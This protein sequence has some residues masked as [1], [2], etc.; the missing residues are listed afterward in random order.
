MKLR[1]GALLVAGL[2]ALVV[3]GE[4]VAQDAANETG[5][6]VYEK[7]CS[8]CHGEDGNGKGIAAPFLK[9]APRDFTS[10]KYKVRTTP[11]G[12]LPT[13][14]DLQRVL[15]RG[16]P[17]S[18]MPAFP[19]LSDAEV[20]AVVAHIKGFSPDFEDPEAYQD[21][22]PIPTPPPY[23]EASVERGRE[24]YEQ[25]G[26]GRC[27]G[28]F[29]R[30]DGSSAPTLVD[31]WGVH[32]RVADLTMPWTFRG[33]G[34]RTD[35]FRTM[36][37]GF[38]GTPMPGF[39]GAL[40]VEDIWGITD[41]MVSLSG[42]TTEEPYGELLRAVST[43]E[44][45]DL[46]RGRELFASAP[47]TVFPIVGQIVEPGREFHPSA[48]AVM[49]RAIYNA[50]EIAFMVSWHDMRAETSGSN[51]PDL[52]VP[53]FE[54]RQGEAGADEEGDAGEDE[55]G[56]WGDEVAGDDSAEEGGDFWGDAAV[57]EDDD[58]GDGGDDFWGDAAADD[59]GGGDD[60][61]GQDEG[62]VG[63]A[64][65][66]EGPD[67]E[68]SDAVA[69]QLPL[70]MPQGIVKPYILF[71]DAQNPVELWLAD[72]AADRA[73]LYTARGS[74]AIAP[75]ESEPP[76]MVASY[77]EGEWTVIYKRRRKGRGSI[78]FNE[79]T[80]VPIAFTVWDGFNRERGNKRGLTRWYNLYL[81]PVER[82]SPFGP[83][84]RAGIGVLGLEILLIF[85]VRRRAKKRRETT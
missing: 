53:R 11:T 29:G 36:S 41:Y 71:G 28:N 9:P 35:I 67:T 70:T 84:A 60:F 64:Q 14:A 24:L 5:R 66:P 31:D 20:Q 61:W 16:L 10:G 51:A 12:S 72:T 75:G 17:Y 23:T 78:S 30:G 33:G 56:F 15:R 43:E 50:D 73:Q 3:P 81:E 63:A 80:F 21:P 39:H 6:A 34:T 82:P 13:D 18:S 77:E 7:Y 69:I 79:D 48:I 57:A 37:S 65:L 58:A 59:S 42:N 45:L 38:N 44:E 8:Q 4:V 2:L 19:N 22:I 1:S 62:A 47:E 49:A 76:E 52:P 25:T 68:F 40:P 85:L 55:G 83:M 54:E 26:C 32:I 74:A 46:A 27:H